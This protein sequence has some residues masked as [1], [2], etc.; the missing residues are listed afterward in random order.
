MKKFN[1]KLLYVEDDNAIRNSMSNLLGNILFENPID[2]AENGLQGFELFKENTYDLIITDIAMPKMNGLE[3]AKKIREIN[4][5]IPI[6]FITGFIEEY[7][8]DIKLV[9]NSYLIIKPLDIMT[10]VE[11]VKEIS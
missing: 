5:D 10:L 3:M 7:K 4:K 9:D 1:Q 6:I 11:K 2:I 8:K